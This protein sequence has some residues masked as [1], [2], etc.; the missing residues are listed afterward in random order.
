MAILAGDALL[1]LGFEM[2]AQCGLHVPA[3]RVVDA[4][5]M[6]ATASGTRGMVGGQVSDIE[7]EGRNDLTEADVRSI[8]ARK[9]GAL[10]KA[11]IVASARLCGATVEQE[12]ALSRYGDRIGL[13]F[14]IADDILD[15]EGDLRKIG[16]PV[17]SDLKQDKATYPKV[18]GIEKSRALAEVAA[19]EAVD[20]LAAFPESAEPLR[21]LAAYVVEREA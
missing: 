8:H 10:L 13:A 7:A 21:S 15:L 1:A 14:Q 16:K 4:I 19:Q 20:A 18:L 9:T 3:H 2:I 17:G 12:A 11:S 5:L 6:V